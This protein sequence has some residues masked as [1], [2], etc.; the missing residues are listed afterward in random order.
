M[1]LNFSKQIWRL[2]E[3]K[4]NIINVIKTTN[5][6]KRKTWKEILNKKSL[7]ERKQKREYHLLVNDLALCD[8]EMGFF[9][10][11]RMNQTKFE[12]LLCCS[13]DNESNRKERTHGFM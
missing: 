5:Q 8:Y 12:E 10:Q 4:N 11:F 6:K 3:G 7:M 2:V 9:S 13:F 1:T